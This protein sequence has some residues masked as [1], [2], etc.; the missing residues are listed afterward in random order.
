MHLLRHLIRP[1]DLLNLWIETD[2]LR[3]DPEP[4]GAGSCD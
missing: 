2:N 3:L 1:D 4:S